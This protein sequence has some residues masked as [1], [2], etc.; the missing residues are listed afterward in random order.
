MSAQRDA[1]SAMPGFYAAQGIRKSYGAIQVLKGISLDLKP[2][3]MVT[4]MGENGAGKST[5]FKILAGQVPPTGGTL[6]LAGAPVALASPSAA[7]AR[8]I[9]LVPQEPALLPE[10]SV[11]ETM[12]VGAL[13]TRGGPL[14][15]RVDWA[16]MRARAR[17]ALDAL[18]LPI[19]VDR[20]A[21]TLSIAQQQ[22]VE[23][24]KALLRGCRII[25]FDEPTSPLTS[26]EVEHLFSIMRRLKADGCTLS[27]ISHRMDEVLEISDEI[28]VLR[29][30]VLVDV[31]AR[32]SFDRARLLSRMVGRPLKAV[33]RRAA[34]NAR[35]EVALEVRGLSDGLRFADVGFSLRR[36]EVLGLA[37]LVGAGRTEI[38]ETVFGVRP[39]AAGEVR[40]GGAVVTGLDCHAMIRRGLVYVPEDRAR[41]GAVLP[42]T[43]TENVTSGLLDRVRRRAGL[44][45][46]RD[47]ARISAAAVRDFR[48]RCAGLDQPLRELS[49]GNQQK[50]VF[51]KWMTTGPRVA[52]LDEPTRG[53][54]VGAKED[55]Y[56]MIDAMARDGMALLVISSESE[57]LVRLCDR[58]L[59]IYEGRV[60]AELSGADISPAAVAR[61]YLTA[62]APSGG[63]AA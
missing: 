49:G 52:I 6:R 24:A 23:C 30:G 43:I 44:L 34:S 8:G 3:R 27:F 62:A 45:S 15:R 56:E 55:I 39:A 54:D 4:I 5:L 58:I 41:H 20:P 26:H 16:A 21:R 7:H 42:M 60:V 61:S 33:P 18:E 31:V 10:L 59:S 63:V 50:V 40:L 12:F 37:G 46:A 53:V 35:D 14:G 11:A 48:V 13:P 32:P 47:E 17:A 19:D 51:A 9:Y 1:D 29:D 25:L 57:E 22:Q 2:G 38:A 36:G 28:A